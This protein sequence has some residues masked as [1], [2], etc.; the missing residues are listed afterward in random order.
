[1]CWL[2]SENGA[3]TLVQP[4]IIPLMQVHRTNLD[5][6]DQHAVLQQ[7][8]R[9]SSHRPAD[10]AA[11]NYLGICQMRLLMLREAIASFEQA[12]ALVPDSAEIA[13]NLGTVLFMTG[14][15]E[16]SAKAL[17]QAVSL[18]PQS[19]EA[20]TSL[21]RTLMALRQY[22]P[23][24]QHVKTALELNPEFVPALI[25]LSQLLTQGGRAKEAQAS[26]EEAVRLEPENAPA[27]SVLGTALQ[28]QG[29]LEDADR[30]FLK[31]I[32]IQPVQGYAYLNFMQDRVVTEHDRGIL[33]TMHGLTK[34]PGLPLSEIQMLH[35]G[36]GRAHEQ[37]HEYEQAMASYDEANRIA[38][39]LKFEGRPFDRGAFVAMRTR[40]KSF[41]SRE[42]FERFR[43][44][45]SESDKPIFIIGMMRSGTT[46]MEH[47]L[48][49]HPEV[50]AA[51]E[52]E[53]WNERGPQ[54]FDPET[55]TLGPDRIREIGDEFLA[56]LSSLSPAA[57]RVTDKMP[58]NDLVLG[59]IH[60]AFPNARIIHMN[61]NP[62]D[63]CMSIYA[64]PNEALFEFGHDRANIA[65]A[66]EVHCDLM[67]HWRTVLPSDR[68]ID[69]VYEELTE[70]HERITRKVLEFCG[71]ES[72]D[73]CLAPEQNVR[74]VAT[75]SVW[76]VRQP[77]YKSSVGRWRNFEQWIP[78][79]TALLPRY[80]RDA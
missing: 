35:Y 73:L 51:G 41:F 46:L 21:G 2:R 78:E 29:F 22:P 30:H 79:F 36:L 53:F 13:Q 47:I 67:E 11:L 71:L 33:E 52:L 75:P 39:E 64:T 38:L 14:S 31:S 48:S 26:A 72:S 6:G 56:L 44:A 63:T 10:G 66:Y 16:G 61:R 49:S 17:E 23:A 42:L 40:V 74:A 57:K 1:M 3:S 5:A 37:L 7:A 62:A 27:H 19:V 43:S 70:D 58:A 59:F 80:L 24:I 25:L 8:I 15:H 12:H 68:L 50:E 9:A 34:G 69:V 55:G 77:L 18:D 54:E 65:F 76:Q 32:Q 60:A 4:D 45:G 28:S 20:H